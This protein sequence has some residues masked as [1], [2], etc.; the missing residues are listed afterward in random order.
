[1]SGLLGGENHIPNRCKHIDDGTSFSWTL[2]S[3]VNNS[4]V[5]QILQ[6][7]SILQIGQ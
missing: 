4:S 2:V 7:G 3:I 6:M 5:I 1:M